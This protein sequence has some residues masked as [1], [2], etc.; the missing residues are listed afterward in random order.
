M[1]LSKASYNMLDSVGQKSM[2]KRVF[3]FEGLLS[4]LVYSMLKV[5]KSVYSLNL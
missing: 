3:Y 2:R 4:Y 5:I 1:N